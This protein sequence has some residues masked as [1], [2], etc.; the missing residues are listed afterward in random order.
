MVALL[1]KET[2]NKAEIAEIFTDLNRRPQRPAWT[3]SDSRIP[4]NRAAG[5]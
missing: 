1:E 3:G 5:A 2:L 4:S